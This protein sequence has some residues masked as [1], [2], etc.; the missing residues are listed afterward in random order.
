MVED[1]HDA[2]MSEVTR[3]LA[4]TLAL[5]LTLNPNLNPNP[6]ADDNGEVSFDGLKATMEGLMDPRAAGKVSS[7]ALVFCSC[8]SCVALPCL[9]LWLSSLVL[10]LSC[11]VLHC[12]GV[13]LVL[14]PPTLPSRPCVHLQPFTTSVLERLFDMFD[15]NKEGKVGAAM[16]IPLL[17]CLAFFC[18]VLSCLV[19]SCLVVSCLVLSCLVLVLSRLVLPCTA[20]SCLSFSFLLCIVVE[21]LS[22]LI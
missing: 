17:S 3:I 18:L 12:R 19:F 11:L 15:L 20:F 16:V 10:C 21:V 6:K 13:S 4:L 2:I 1:I 22:Y 7:L 14:H 5:T 9:V 8:M